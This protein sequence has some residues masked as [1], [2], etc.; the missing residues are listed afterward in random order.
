M[1]KNLPA[2]A[3]D[4]R[5][6]DSIPASGRSPEEGHG[7]PL[8]YSCLQNPMDKGAWGTTVHGVTKSRT[9]LKQL[10]MHTHR[11]ERFEQMMFFKLW[12]LEVTH[13]VK[14]ELNGN[15]LYPEQLSFYIIKLMEVCKRIPLLKPIFLKL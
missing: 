14:E 10:S 6:K 11:S 5:D 4:T 15:P 3:G 9:R 12:I 8:Q 13:R 7:N 1:V 2:N